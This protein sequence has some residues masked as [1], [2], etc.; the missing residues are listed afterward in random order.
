MTAPEVAQRTSTLPSAS[1]ADYELRNYRLHQLVGHD[2]LATIYTATHLTLD[3]PVLVHILRRS[4]WVSVS[5]FQLAGRLAARLNHPNL[6][7]VIDAGHDETYGYYLVTPQIDARPLSEVLAQDA[8]LDPLLVLRV[9]TQL[10]SVLDYLHGQQVY[11]R[12]I[13]PSS[14][15]LSSEGVAYLTN[16][17][18]A[19][20]PDTPDLSSVDEADYL[21][22]YSAP[23]Q[24][25]DQGSASPL[26]D[27]YSM[28]ALLYHMLSGEIPPSPGMELVALAT[29]DP[30]LADMDRVLARMLSVEPDKRYKSVGEVVVALRRAL[31]TH[32]D[33]STED[34]EESRWEPTAEWLENPLETVLGEMLDTEYTTRSRTRA[35]T[36][37]RSEAISRLLNRWSRKGF[38]RRRMLGNII[39]LEQ[40]V[41]Y[42][43]Y[44]YE[45]Q[46][47]YETRKEQEPRRRP[48]KTD[49]QID[50]YARKSP[51]PVWDVTVPD[52]AA[53]AE[54]KPQEVLLPDSTIIFPCYECNGEARVLCSRCRGKGTVEQTRKLKNAD[55]ST[56]VEAFDE[57]CPSCRGYRY[58]RCTVCDGTGNLVE[59]QF[60]LWSRRAYVWSNTDDIDELPSLV[61][62]KRAEPVY[63][64]SVNPYQGH[65]H[66][67]KPL[68]ELFKEAI[69]DVKDEH[70]RMV[71]AELHIRGVPITE[72]DYVLDEK[73]YRLY[74]VG[75]D[76]EVVGSWKLLNL[77]RILL[78]VGGCVVLLVLAIVILVVVF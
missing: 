49:E 7:P 75:H 69:A 68:G 22:P 1:D 20:S 30:F 44:F 17:G 64:A 46:T 42:N 29:H 14:V 39:R 53:F 34:M 32:I 31:H 55:G 33:R 9:A 4:D 61:L 21:T 50:P 26:L 25:L 10:A 11:H 52:A 78:V 77:E 70:T 8:P 41:S 28:G 57:M 60:F 5:R 43:I 6:L 16:L 59:E 54:V 62:Q 47:L 12:D 36:L 72:V 56:S 35:D 38:F 71:D 65:W 45:L 27:I 19:A 66:S 37:H 15:I 18:L 63:H 2:E 74:L 58:Q 3:R 13:Q 40:I 67:V 48:Q 51:P 73:K 23:E 76:N 24:R